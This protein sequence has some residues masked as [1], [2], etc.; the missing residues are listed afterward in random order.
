[1]EVFDW[2]DDYYDEGDERQMR[3]HGTGYQNTIEIA[4]R[5]EEKKEDED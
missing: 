4:D 1:M 2:P 5:N 3:R